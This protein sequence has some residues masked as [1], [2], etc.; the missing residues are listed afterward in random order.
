LLTV[1]ETH[2]LKEPFALTPKSVGGRVL[3]NLALTYL[4]APHE[5]DFLAKAEQQFERMDNMTDVS[6][7]LRALVNASHVA[8]EPMRAQALETFFERWS[9]EALVI[10]QW[11][12]IQAAC[13]RPGAIARIE[14]LMSHPAYSMTNPNRM[15]SV[16]AGFAMQNLAAFHQVDGSGYRLLAEKVLVLNGFNPQMAA[17]ML[18]PLTGW[19]KFSDEHGQAMQSALQSILDEGDLSPDVY[20]VVTKSLA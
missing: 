10:D 3:K 2:D 18:G 20:E 1:F 12:S 7:A 8:A 16:L 9:T 13:P 17:R 19:R 15:R 5:T 4:L 11:F 6:A 14:T